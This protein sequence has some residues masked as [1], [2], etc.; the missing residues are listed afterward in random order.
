MGLKIDKKLN[1]VIP[2]LGEPKIIKDDQDRNVEVDNVV[3]Y[4]HATPISR[5]VFDAYYM[6]LAKT[7]S[8]LYT[9]GLNW[10]IGPRVAYL[11]L[12]TAATEANQWDGPDGVQAGLVNEIRRLTNVAVPG[13]SGWT[14]VPYSEAITKGLISEDDAAE[15]DN[16][17]TFFI[18]AS[19]MHIRSEVRTVVTEA[20]QL[21]G[22][23]TTS[24]NST[25]FAASLQTSTGDASS[26]AR[27]A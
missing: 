21:W 19:A 10:R 5:D 23:R 17:I 9:E 24:L 27:A 6:I 4:V 3:A 26:G 8:K 7:F 2:I 14:T 13:A 25:E 22:G 20:A 15:V 18:V 11:A 1:L 16:A 12:K